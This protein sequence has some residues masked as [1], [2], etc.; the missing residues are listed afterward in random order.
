MLPF[1]IEITVQLLLQYK[2]LYFALRHCQCKSNVLCSSYQEN[3][4]NHVITIRIS[5][6]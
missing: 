3:Q 6:D 1:C 5:T 2:L 4:K